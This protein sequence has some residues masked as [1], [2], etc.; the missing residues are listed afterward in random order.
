MARSVSV[1][2]P[3]SV[4]IEMIETKLAELN[5]AETDYPKLLSAYK[6]DIVAFTGN[7]LDLAN[8][9]KKNVV[10]YGDYEFE[11]GN[12]AINSDWRGS[13]SIAL[14][15]ELVAKIGTKPEKPEDPNT[16]QTKDKKKNLEKTLKLLRLTDQ[17]TITSST[18]NSVLDLL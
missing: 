1:K 8:K 17:E 13:V 10:D 18:Y 15:K 9:N 16:W 11:G 7:L 2:I 6:K 5:K 3:T 12:I 14:G 4:V